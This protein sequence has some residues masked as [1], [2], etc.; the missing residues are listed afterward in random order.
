MRTLVRPL[1]KQIGFDDRVSPKTDFDRNDDK[2][3]GNHLDVHMRETVV[4]WACTLRL[5]ECCNRV[6]REFDR[7]SGQEDP[8]EGNG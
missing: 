5:P 3:A 8:D 1:Y 4:D 2:I 7:W 6:K